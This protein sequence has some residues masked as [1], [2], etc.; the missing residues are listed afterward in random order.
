VD[1]ELELFFRRQTG[2]NRLV[3]TFITS[4]RSLSHLTKIALP[5]AIG[6]DVES[7]MLS[8]AKRLSRAGKLREKFERT[9]PS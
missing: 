3:L 8:W 1:K 7:V 9:F 4:K 5:Y 2:M 6:R